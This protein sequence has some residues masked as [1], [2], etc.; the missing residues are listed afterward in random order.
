MKKKLIGFAQIKYLQLC[1]PFHLPSGEI[2]YNSFHLFKS[3]D[4]YN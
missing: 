1:D 2:Y 4:I 3:V